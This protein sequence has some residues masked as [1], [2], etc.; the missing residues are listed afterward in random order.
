MRAL[1]LDTGYLLALELAHDQ[2]HPQAQRHWQSLL[3][4][5]PPLLTTSFV[6]NETVTFFN[7]RGHH[8]KAVE[9]GNNLL[10]SQSVTLIHVG[11]ELFRAGWT[12]AAATTG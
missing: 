11:E 4:R 10:N 6:F 5:L 12:A 7:H 1:F 8:A 2:H 3:T 9:V